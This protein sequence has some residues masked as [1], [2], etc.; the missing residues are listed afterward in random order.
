MRRR[1]FSSRPV[2][3]ENGWYLHFPSTPNSRDFRPATFSLDSAPH[4]VEFSGSAREILFETTKTLTTRSSPFFPFR[5][6]TLCN[7]SKRKI[8]SPLLPGSLRVEASNQL[9][10][11]ASMRKKNPPNCPQWFISDGMR[12]SSIPRNLLQVGR[13]LARMFLRLLT[14][15]EGGAGHNDN[16]G[17]PQKVLD[18]EVL[19]HR[20]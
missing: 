6:R 17:V 11:A 1:S 2:T 18:F 20:R 5:V 14:R 12:S 19:I 8:C 16:S 15:I 7:N 4:L 9:G 10:A 13:P 3:T